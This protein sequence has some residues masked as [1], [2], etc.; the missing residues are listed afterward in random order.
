M[1]AFAT[2]SA[3]GTQSRSPAFTGPVTGSAA[4]RSMGIE[5]G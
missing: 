4:D 2:R 5:A 1:F 3:V